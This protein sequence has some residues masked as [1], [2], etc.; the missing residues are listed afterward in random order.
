[1]GVEKRSPAVVLAFL[2]T[3]TVVVRIMC[4]C[5]TC[6]VYRS[7]REGD[8]VGENL[9]HEHEGEKREPNQPGQTEPR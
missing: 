8:N 2:L 3:R 9:L 6:C 7:A 5:I 1:M 4:T